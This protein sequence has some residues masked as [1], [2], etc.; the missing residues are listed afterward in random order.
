MDSRVH[1]SHPHKIIRQVRAGELHR[2]ARAE[3]R[4]AGA[5]AAGAAQLALP[6]AKVMR[7]H[8]MYGVLHHIAVEGLELRAGWVHLPHL[9]VVAALER[10]LGALRLSVGTAAAGPAHGDRRHR[11]PSAGYYGLH[12]VAVS[13][14]I[15]ASADITRGGAA[16]RLG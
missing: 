9:P 2:A 8:L 4:D 13:D 7:D 10:N 3:G 5:G 11:R 6:A 1:K 15:Q 12:P 14:L 16:P